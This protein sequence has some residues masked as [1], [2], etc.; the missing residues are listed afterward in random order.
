MKDEP[1]PVMVRDYTF[2]MRA[3]DMRDQQTSY[4]PCTRK[5]K[6]WWLRLFWWILDASVNNAHILYNY[7]NAEVPLDNRKYREKLIYE[8]IGNMSRT[9]D[10]PQQKRRTQRHGK[11]GGCPVCPQIISESP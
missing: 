8:L 2:G 6:R 3:V 10:T 9:D 11:R 5:A 4:Y 7:Y 1:Y